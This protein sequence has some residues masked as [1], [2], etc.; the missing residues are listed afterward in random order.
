MTT[1]ELQTAVDAHVG[2]TVQSAEAFN[3]YIRINFTDGTSMEVN[4][5]SSDEAAV[6]RN[7]PWGCITVDNS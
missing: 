6:A 7:R 5:Y 3:S 1:S 2:K 4:A